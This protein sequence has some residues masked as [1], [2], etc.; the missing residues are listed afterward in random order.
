MLRALA[1]RGARVQIAQSGRP[2]PPLTGLDLILVDLAHGSGLNRARVTALNRR[3]G[4]ALVVAL[5]YGALA[6]ER[7]PGAD[8]AVE[9]FV[10]ADA[11]H[12]LLDALGSAP[13]PVA[14]S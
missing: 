11:W 6:H 3:P 8:L 2:L 10:H 14:M 5:H 12:P 13:I 9:G 4:R 1:R 7:A